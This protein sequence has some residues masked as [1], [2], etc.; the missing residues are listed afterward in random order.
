[1]MTPESF[2]IDGFP[3]TI[4][5]TALDNVDNLPDATP[6]AIV[7][8]IAAALARGKRHGG[9]LVHELEVLFTWTVSEPATAELPAPRPPKDN[10][11][12]ETMPPS[13][14]TSAMN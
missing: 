7:E 13:Y 6:A 3:V 14:G 8:R 10:L 1:M 4:T 11:T 2:V 12:G 5:V 9:I